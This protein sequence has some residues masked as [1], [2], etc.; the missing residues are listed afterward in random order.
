[1]RGALTGG[2]EVVGR[3]DEAGA[4]VLLPDAVDDD[5]G[6]EGVFFAG[7]GLGE[8]EAA[9]VGERAGVD[10]G[11]DLRETARD[12]VAGFEAVAANE[13]VGIDGRAGDGDGLGAVDGCGGF[14]DGELLADLGG[15]LVVFAGD[16]L[17][18]GDKA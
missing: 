1:M 4:E 12:G 14:E 17:G 15:G 7:E 2:A 10:G 11:E 18:L 16:D 3:G 13:N 9:I 8:S 6:G 5:A